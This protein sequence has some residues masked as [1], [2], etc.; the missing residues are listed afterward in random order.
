MDMHALDICCRLPTGILRERTDMHLY[1][2]VKVDD[3]IQYTKSFASLTLLCRLP[4][5]N[6][7]KS[8]SNL[9]EM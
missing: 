2:L 9:Q 1:F 7:A 6:P 8:H 5:P 4:L 3:E